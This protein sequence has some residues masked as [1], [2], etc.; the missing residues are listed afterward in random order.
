V[1]ARRAARLR[2][3]FVGHCFVLVNLSKIE[4]CEYVQTLGSSSEKSGDTPYLDRVFTLGSGTFDAT[5][6]TWMSLLMALMPGR[7][8][9][10]NAN[11]KCLRR[12]GGGSHT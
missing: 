9:E 2:V 6:T 10:G 7:Q 12:L 5:Y 3:C 11:Q 4:H 8:T 1:G